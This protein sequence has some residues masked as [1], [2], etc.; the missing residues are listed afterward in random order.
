MAGE[1]SGA[2]WV[3]IEILHYEMQRGVS[4][5]V[6]TI[7]VDFSVLILRFP[8]QFDDFECV[9]VVFVED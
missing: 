2:K 5:V 1:F 8:E 7:E 9:F 6:C 3:S 4:F